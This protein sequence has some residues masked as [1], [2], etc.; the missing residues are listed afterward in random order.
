MSEKAS[1][2]DLVSETDRSSAFRSNPVIPA[3][4]VRN[5][6]FGFKRFKKN[7]TKQNKLHV[8]VAFLPPHHLLHLLGIPAFPLQSH[9]PEF[10]HLVSSTS[11]KVQ[12]HNRAIRQQRRLVTK[13]H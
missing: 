7:K 8:S 1:F 5:A 3:P 6:S 13:T 4:S 12:P 9:C 2:S 11:S 10:Q